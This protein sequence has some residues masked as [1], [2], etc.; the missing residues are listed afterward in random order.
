MHTS[1]RTILISFASIFLLAFA[2]N[3][4]A[5][6][7]KYHNIIKRFIEDVKNRDAYSMSQYIVFPFKRK[8]PVPSIKSK[9]DFKKR[10]DQLFDPGLT[11][12]I[13]SSDVVNDWSAV[14]W[15]GIMLKRGI[16]WIYYDGRLL[17]VNYQSKAEKKLTSDLIKAQMGSLH[18]SV[19]DF[20]KPI[21]NWETRKFKIRI[22]DLGGRKYRYASW[23]IDKQ[24]S[25][26][27]DLILKKGELV[28]EGSVGNHYYLFKNGKYSYRLF[29]NNIGK[30]STP[31]GELD[32]FKSGKN[33]LH[34]EVVNVV[35]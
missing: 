14:G 16:V 31:V 22:D 11:E 10:F 1:T 3:S 12:V 9:E 25:D 23:G 6:E 35:Q 5:V 15:R 2:N 18:E 33:I 32:V 29:V 13:V 28:F 8:H 20:D 27:P 19:K 4:F 24:Y 17:A 26:K 7:E 21:L 30:S 34:D